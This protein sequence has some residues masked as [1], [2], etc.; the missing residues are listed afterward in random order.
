MC[1]CVCEAY[2]VT[3]FTYEKRGGGRPDYSRVKVLRTKASVPD[4]RPAGRTGS[5][6]AVGPRGLLSPFFSIQKRVKNRRGDN[7]NIKKEEDENM[8]STHKVLF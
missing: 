1:V 5:A 2:G 4:T 7:N 6:A 8:V 3:C